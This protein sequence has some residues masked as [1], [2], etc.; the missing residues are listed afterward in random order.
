MYEKISYLI[1][2]RRMEILNE[3]MC[4]AFIFSPIVV[5]AVQQIVTRGIQ[6]L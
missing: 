6:M 4:E 1:G 5:S 2:E 3:A